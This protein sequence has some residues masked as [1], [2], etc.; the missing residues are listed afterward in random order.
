MQRRHGS[1]LALRSGQCTRLVRDPQA[2]EAHRQPGRV[3]DG[4]LRRVLE[5]DRIGVVDVRVDAVPARERR[6]AAPGCRRGPAIGRWS[7]SRAVRVADAR[8]R[9]AR[10]PSRTSRRRAARRL[11]PSRSSSGG[12]E[13]AAAR[14]RTRTSVPLAS[15][16]MHQS[17]RVSCLLARRR[18]AAA[19]PAR[20][21]PRPTGRSAHR[22]GSG[23]ARADSAAARSRARR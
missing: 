2:V 21:T 3:D 8:A 13:I 14:A 11:A 15:S 10:R 17:D 7:I 16:R 18:I 4:A 12:V 22:H 5:Q 9:S 19:R 20:R 1:D 23:A 6:Q